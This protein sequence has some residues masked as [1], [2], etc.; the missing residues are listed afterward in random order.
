LGLFDAQDQKVGSATDYTQS[1]TPGK[2]WKFKALVLP[3]DVVRA[4][5]VSVTEQP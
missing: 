2:E 1:I 4:E 5:L 3:R